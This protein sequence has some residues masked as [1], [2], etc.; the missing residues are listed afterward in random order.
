M[1]LLESLSTTAD[2]TKEIV[3]IGKSVL[4]RDIFAFVKGE[5]PKYKILIHGGIHAR[6]YITS[7]LVCEL[8]KNY[9]GEAEIW[10]VPIVNPDGVMLCLNGL[11][12]VPYY[13]HNE[14]M[15][16]NKGSK[17]FSMWK[18]NI[19]GVDL[20]V[21]FDALWGTGEQ[22]IEY[23]SSENYIGP[24]PFSE[25][26]TVALK[27]ITNMNDFILT[28]SY[29]CKGQEIYWGFDDEYRFKKE[30]KQFSNLLKYPLKKSL[31]SAGGYKDWYVSNV[32]GLGLTIEVGDDKYS[33]PL[34]DD[35]FEEIYQ[36]NKHI[37]ELCSDIS[38]SIYNQLD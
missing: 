13:R 14:L 37:P 19:E 22:N 25:P 28:I 17:D 8:A 30:A 4:G 36:R 1:N 18:S 5:N 2:S 35:V 3:S 7:K 12:S 38:K 9:D 10:F 23:P 31:K 20:N 11:E 27:N 34:D 16:M 24:Y 6:E 26:E 29:H 15:I 33:H 32:N 21:N